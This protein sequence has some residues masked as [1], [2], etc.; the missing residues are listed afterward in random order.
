MESLAKVAPSKALF[1]WLEMMAQ[2]LSVAVIA[3]HVR[4]HMVCFIDNTAAEHALRK[5][6][7]RVK[8]LPRRWH[9]FGLGS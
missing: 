5:F 2:I 9:A 1:Y 3:P 8:P 7:P 6:M 4:G